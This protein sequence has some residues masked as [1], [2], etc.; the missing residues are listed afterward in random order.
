MNDADVRALMTYIKVGMLIL[1]ARIFALLAVLMT[2]G[3]FCW[4]MWQPSFDREI[5][6]GGFAF[7]VFL[8]V[9]LKTAPNLATPGE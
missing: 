5:L 2:F 8:P 1:S 7:L 6:A 9:L 3:L 4:A